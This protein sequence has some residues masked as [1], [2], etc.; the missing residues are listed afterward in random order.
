MMSKYMK[1]Y[2]CLFSM[3]LNHLI[4]D[5]V[6]FHWLMFV[7]DMFFLLMR[8]SILLHILPISDLFGL[9]S[10]YVGLFSKFGLWSF[11]VMNASLS[12]F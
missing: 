6:F 1:L 11:S 9:I 10:R 12:L 7:G 2:C 3:F 4:T 5:F 8:S